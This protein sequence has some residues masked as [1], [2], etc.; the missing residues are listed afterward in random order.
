MTLHKEKSTDI[1]RKQRCLKFLYLQSYNRVATAGIR[2]QSICRSGCFG[3]SFEWGVRIDYGGSLIS[4]EGQMEGA[5]VAGVQ[6]G[7]PRSGPECR[8]PRTGQFFSSP[9]FLAR[10]PVHQ[11]YLLAG[12]RCALAI[13]RRA[14]RGTN[15]TP[16]TAKGAVSRLLR[17]SRERL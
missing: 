3:R 13:S 11:C 7:N 8:Q 1:R 6:S 14:L 17:G 5:T 12:A 10:K 15:S 16:V 9:F 2:V 4:L